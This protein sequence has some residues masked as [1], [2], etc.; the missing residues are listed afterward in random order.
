M[1]DYTELVQ[2]LRDDNAW[3]NCDFDFIY[4]WMHEAADAIEELAAFK[5]QI[6]DGRFYVYKLGTLFELRHDPRELVVRYQD[7]TEPPK[8][9]TNY[10]RIVSKT[11][12]ELAEYL[13]NVAYDLWAMFVADPKKMWLDWLKSPAEEGET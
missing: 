3:K 7:P 8:P 1:T 6:T 11:P 12:E 2:H 10:D 13:A 4:G 5:A 9:I